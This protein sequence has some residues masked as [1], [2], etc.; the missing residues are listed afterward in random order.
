[1]VRIAFLF[2]NKNMI[3]WH[4]KIMSV[5]QNKFFKQ[6][7]RKLLG[8]ILILEFFPPSRLVNHRIWP[9]LPLEYF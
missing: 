1:M 3:I 9:I 5:T 4:N 7:L 2:K 6:N 8:L